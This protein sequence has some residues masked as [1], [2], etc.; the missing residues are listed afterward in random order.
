MIEF[1]YTNMCK[2]EPKTPCFKWPKKNTSETMFINIFVTSTDPIPVPARVCR[3]LL[4][5]QWTERTSESFLGHG[6]RW[7]WLL[8]VFISL[9]SLSGCCKHT[10]MFCTYEQ[11]EFSF[12]LSV[13]NNF[14][15]KNTLQFKSIFF[16]NISIWFDD[17]HVN[18]FLRISFFKYS[19][20]G[21]WLSIYDR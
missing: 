18:K 13:I 6:R 12:S 7:W 15:D 11:T 19:Q 1:R 4:G 20:A 10:H 5:A 17:I 9:L 16:Y 8:T 3:V 2:C 14:K 21:W